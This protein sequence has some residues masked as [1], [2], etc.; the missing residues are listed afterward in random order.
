M[1]KILSIALV[2][3]MILSCTCIV[4][5]ADGEADG[6]K[7]YVTLSNA[8]SL[9]LSRAELN[10]AD[11]DSDNAITVNDVL[12]A[13]H[14]KFF[15]G[16]AAVGYATA[17]TEWGLSLTKLWG[18]ENGGSYGYY[19]NNNAAMSLADTVNEGDHVNAFV[20]SD[21]NAWTD[22][23]CWFDKDMAT[24]KADGELELT[25]SYNVYDE[26]YN[27]T[28]TPVADAT[29]T[30]DGQKTSFKTDAQ[31]KVSVKFDN[32]GE[33]IVSA[34]SDTQVLVP[35][36]CVVGVEASA[37][38]GTDTENTDTSET[39]EAPQDEETS[40]ETSDSDVEN[41]NGNDSAKTVATAAAVAVACAIIVIAVIA[42]IRRKK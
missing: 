36:V 34:V 7:V 1:K 28:K 2:M 6:I 23:Y 13:A 35:T 32:G 22:T 9:V 29:I 26:N 33:H 41:A 14:D 39:T 10:V 4:S 24:V 21:L 5:L 16:D 40:G 8:G 30:I 27:A 11:T 15:G 25:L 31:G 18:V 42:F 17:K 38:T 12:Y 3:M 19:V 37:P 20:Y